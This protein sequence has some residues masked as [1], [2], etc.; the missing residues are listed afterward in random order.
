MMIMSGG[1]EMDI[2]SENQEAGDSMSVQT[3]S[4]LDVTSGDPVDMTVD[5]EPLEN[6]LIEPSFD[7]DDLGR[8]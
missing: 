5:M 1:D 7:L 6:F 4:D 3:Q 8:S 2:R